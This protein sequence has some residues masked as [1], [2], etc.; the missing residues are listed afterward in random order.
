LDKSALIL[1]IAGQNGRLLTELLLNK[2]Y[3]VA[4]FGWKDSIE[5]S[6]SLRPFRDRIA[7]CYGDL[8]EPE[9]LA[10]AMQAHQYSE[11]YNFAAQSRPDLSWEIAVETGEVNAFGAHRLFEA[12]RRLQPQA[13]IFQASSS[14]MFGAASETPQRETTPFAAINPYAM[15]KTYAHQTAAIYRQ[16]HGTYIACGILYNHES[17][18]RDMAFLSQK[19]TYGAVCAKLG[20]RNSPLKNE[21]GEPMV[22]DGKLALGSLEATRDWGYAGDYVQAMWLMLQQPQVDDFVIGTGVS[23][24]VREMC[25]TA[26][27]SV[28]LDWREHVVSDP[29]LVRPAETGAAVAD[30]SK[31]KRVLGWQPTTSFKDMLADMVAAHMERFQRS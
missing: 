25:E 22:K 17:R 13:R 18:Y 12:V 8:R 30:A 3:R 28:G 4:G 24:S 2:N 21:Q 29:R 9:S 31:A 27:A 11:I 19:V 20:V 6:A 14:E 7:V 16:Q 1:G 15:S 5:N 26:Y 23:R 10:A